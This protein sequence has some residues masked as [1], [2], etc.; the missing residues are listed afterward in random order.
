MEVGG[1]TE[2]VEVV[3]TAPLLA[4]QTSS[5]GQVIDNAKILNIPLNG[6]SPFRLVLITPGVTSTP[7]AGGSIWRCVGEY[8]PGQRFCH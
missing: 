3:S 8:E 4:E 5:L 2:A 6:R 1:M 7:A